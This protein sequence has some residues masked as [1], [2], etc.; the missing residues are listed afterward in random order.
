MKEKIFNAI[1]VMQTNKSGKRRKH[2]AEAIASGLVLAQ[3][4]LCVSVSAAASISGTAGGNAVE[5]IMGTVLN[6]LQY[7]GGVVAVIGVGQFVLSWQ[8]DDADGK[9]RALKVMMA[10]ALLF[11][12]GTFADKFIKTQGHNKIDN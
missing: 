3:L 5:S 6:W 12:I 9:S 10:G 1:A 4:A 2:K 8:R 11:S 7:V